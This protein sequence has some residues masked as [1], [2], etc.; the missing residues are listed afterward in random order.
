MPEMSASSRPVMLLIAGF[1][2][3]ASMFAD[4]FDTPLED[5]Y[6]LLPLD[7]PGFGDQSL[8]PPTTLKALAEFVTSKAK[9]VNAKIIVAH[10]VASIIASLAAKEPGSPL[11][12][13]LSLEGNLTPEDAYFSGTAADYDDPDT[14]RTAF[15]ER[16]EEMSR[17]N[18]MIAR[19]RGIVTQA[20]PV[21]LWQLG[22]DARR[23]SEQHVPG[24]VL[25]SAADV[26]YFYNPDNCPQSSV[27]WLSRH[28]MRQVKL[29]GASHWASVDQ[30]ELLAEKI[31]SIVKAPNEPD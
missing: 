5:A 30:P 27:E 19:Y 4:L 2:D 28:P 18:P 25:L 3:D 22:T 6:E 21:A 13:I 11:T 29:D 17:S 31:L 15:L 10:S 16:L 8:E 7:L 23:F 24:E 26:T 1:G 20:D 9:E 14:F 12:T